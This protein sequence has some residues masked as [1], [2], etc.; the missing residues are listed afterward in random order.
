MVVLRIACVSCHLMLFRWK[1]N[2]RM[3]LYSMIQ[4]ITMLY[5]L[6]RNKCT[7]AHVALFF[8]RSDARMRPC[9]W[10]SEACWPAVGVVMSTGSSAWR[11]TSPRPHVVLRSI[12]NAWIMARGRTW[13]TA[14]VSYSSF[15]G[16]YQVAARD[17]ETQSVFLTHF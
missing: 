9:S 10:A 12:Q 14:Q 5:Y 17:S 2:V 1:S 4:Q 3:R 7:S 11:V 6:Q 15:P 13:R 8:Q 16:F